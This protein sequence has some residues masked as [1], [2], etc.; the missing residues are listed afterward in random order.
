MKTVT[1]T[2]NVR[3]I[4][5]LL[6]LMLSACA[7]DPKMTSVERS[8]TEVKN[9]LAAVKHELADIRGDRD[10]HGSKYQAF[11]VGQRIW[12]LNTMT[13]SVCIPAMDNT[14]WKK[15]DVVVQSC[16][17]EEQWEAHAADEVLKALGCLPTQTTKIKPL[18]DEALDR[19]VKKFGGR[20]VK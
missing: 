2:W 12:R 1:T 16:E 20:P 8:L 17:C 15:P 10:P 13:G 11:V 19:I 5:G 9:E 7:S 6:T 3:S 4:I 14:E 18:S